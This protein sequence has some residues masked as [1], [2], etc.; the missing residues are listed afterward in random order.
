MLNRV[1]HFRVVTFEEK[2]LHQGTKAGLEFDSREVPV[3]GYPKLTL[4][5]LKWVARP[6]P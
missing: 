1:L 3:P 4:S 6:S 2:H 5:S